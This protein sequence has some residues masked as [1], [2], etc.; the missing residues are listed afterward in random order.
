MKKNNNI[1]RKPKLHFRVLIIDND[2]E[3]RNKLKRS[4]LATFKEGDVQI[5]FEDTQF[6]YVSDINQFDSVLGFSKFNTIWIS[7]EFPNCYELSQII[8][9]ESPFS[10]QV[11]YGK[12]LALSKELLRSRPIGYVKHISNIEEVHNEIR[13]ISACFETER[14]MLRLTSRSS[15]LMVPHKSILFLQSDGRKSYVYLSAMKGV[16]RDEDDIYV[17]KADGSNEVFAYVQNKKLDDLLPQ[18]DTSVFVRVH[19]SYIVNCNY[20][21]GIRKSKYGWLLSLQDDKGVSIQVPVSDPYH[22]AVD[23]L[24]KKMSI[25]QQ[26][27]TS[28]TQ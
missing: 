23:V 17:K 5:N 2:E 13:Y 3:C 11:F 24:V 4:F 6:F 7:T 19:K 12:H 18:L 22:D 20:I 28:S 1:S 27:I 16:E 8:Y 26:I 10:Y 25:C 9:T 14:E 21:C 15:F